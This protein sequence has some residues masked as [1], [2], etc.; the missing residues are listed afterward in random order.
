M[1]DGDVWAIQRKVATPMFKKN[2]WV[3]FHIVFIDVLSLDFMK[4]VFRDKAGIVLELL[5]DKATRYQIQPAA[6]L[7]SSFL[8]FLL[9]CLMGRYPSFPS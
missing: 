1:T 5:K 6:C 3:V 9:E 8:S 4:E 2:R 7:L